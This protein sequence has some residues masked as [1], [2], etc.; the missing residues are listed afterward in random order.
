MDEVIVIE[1][2][3]KNAKVVKKN[4]EPKRKKIVLNFIQKC[5]I[6]EKLK[7]GVRV[8]DLA[9]EYNIGL[10]TVC[11]IRKYGDEK[12]VQFR[13]E[14]LFSMTRKTFKAPD[15]PL[16]DKALR[17][18]VYQERTKNYTLTD[19]IFA[20][21]A[22]EFFKHLYPDAKKAFKASYGYVDKF[23][24]RYEISLRNEPSKMYADLAKLDSFII[25]FQSLNYS[26][27]QIYSADECGLNFKE[28]PVLSPSKQSITLL[29]CCNATGKHRLPLL[30]I[31]NN[32]NPA[33]FEVNTGTKK[34]QIDKA[35]LPVR[36]SHSPK[37]WITLEIF[38]QWF[39]D[40]FVPK[41]RAHLNSL[42]LEE[43]AVL[44]IDN[45]P[46]HPM[47][48]ESSD[49]KIKALFLP[50]DSSS[51]IMPMNQ[52]PITYL[53][54]KYRT[55]LLRNSVFDESFLKNY[56]VR[57]A[58]YSLVNIWREMPENLLC[59][60]WQKLRINL[61]IHYQ[62]EKID[63]NEVQNNFTKLGFNLSGHEINCW[64]DTDYGEPGYGFLTDEEIIENCKQ[65]SL[66]NF[67]LN[68]SNISIENNDDRAKIISAKQA[69]KYCTDLM[70]WL[71][72]HSLATSDDLI[73][74]QRIKELASKYLFD[75]TECEAFV[76]ISVDS[77]S[78]ETSEKSLTT[79][80]DEETP[81][82]PK[83]SI[84][85]AKLNETNGDMDKSMTT[86]L[87][88]ENIGNV[89]R[90]QSEGIIEK[91]VSKKND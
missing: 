81:R 1:K 55:N 22:L 45:C 7:S 36:Y 32:S 37:A 15:F 19:A 83:C 28:I 86:F 70:V 69:Y 52:G 78:D 13:K 31:N 3:R 51:L 64:L 34:H 30:V 77:K 79:F 24:K 29:L 57:S 91:V 80:M 66:T 68:E 63:M 53:K 27:E 35:A 8:V 58:I 39:H 73:S 20:A 40:E 59:S 2:I 23:C 9:K 47:K 85:A 74:M 44:L 38:E 65:S 71:E 12:L 56:N 82:T 84:V 49:G 61:D 16:L 41:T 76:N 26:S 60:S 4:T 90:L 11:D 5:E 18:W 62:Y 75:E 43:K 25:D 48:L 10:S 67:N 21:K 14:N 87:D 6:L 88:E 46:A 54:R 50:P 17:L 72:D 42:N 33:C 89:L